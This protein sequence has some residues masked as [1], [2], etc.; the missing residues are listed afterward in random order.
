MLVK[1][2]SFLPGIIKS[3]NPMHKYPHVEL[4]ACTRKML[5]LMFFFPN[6]FFNFFRNIF[7]TEANVINNFTFVTKKSNPMCAYVCMFINIYYIRPILYFL[8]SQNISRINTIKSW[9]IL[10]ILFYFKVCL[11]MQQQ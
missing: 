3:I 10:I 1:S 7:N 9:F 2:V 6:K 8:F 5:A 4:F 11:W